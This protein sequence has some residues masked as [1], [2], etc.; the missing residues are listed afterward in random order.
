MD[1]IMEFRLRRWARAHYVPAAAR[2]AEWHPVILDEMRRKDEDLAAAR[3][4][5]GLPATLAISSREPP[6]VPA[7]IAVRERE[8]VHHSA[9]GCSY[10]P[11]LLDTHMIHRLDPPHARLADPRLL[12]RIERLAAFGLAESCEATA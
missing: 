5:G 11:L 4:A 12:E 7:T 9:P 2:R 10:V 1:L 6:C 3:A 8:P